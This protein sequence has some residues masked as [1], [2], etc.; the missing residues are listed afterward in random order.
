MLRYLQNMIFITGMGTNFKSEEDVNEYIKNL[1]TE[2]RFGC[3]NEKNPEGT[4][5]GYIYTF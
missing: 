1:G 3:F 2:Y 4:Y 5:L